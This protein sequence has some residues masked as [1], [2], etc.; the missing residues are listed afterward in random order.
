MNLNLDTFIKD[1]TLL[2]TVTSDGYKH[3]TW[4]LQ[5]FF[6][7]VNPTVPLCILCLDRESYDFFNRIAFL[8][9]RPFFMEGPRFEHKQPAVFGTTPFKRLTKMKLKALQELSQRTDI[10]KLIYI[11]SDIALFHDP[12]PILNECWSTAPLW[13]QCDEANKGVYT[14][15]NVD[16]C[17]NAC[18]GVIAMLLTEETRPLY[19]KLYSIED[20]WKSATTDQDY[21]NQRLATLKIP[22]KTLSRDKFPNGIF[23]SDNHYKE[24]D[25]VLL[26][27]N[28]IVGIDKKRFM[29]NKDC[30]LLHV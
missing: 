10:D 23:L 12:L 8:P 18:T 25:P 21:V 22:Y 24:G 29:K 2:F 6:Q 5:L 14:C 13:F 11:D 20:G 17:S 27:F 3:F 9:S 19:N 1:R 16:N 28:Q 26:H 15:S 7:K 30:W 4:N